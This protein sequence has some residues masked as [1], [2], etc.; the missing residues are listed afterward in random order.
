MR[1]CR[2]VDS[3]CWLKGQHGAMPCRTSWNEA[4]AQ[5]IELEDTTQL[6]RGATPCSKLCLQLVPRTDAM[7]VK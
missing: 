6:R 3:P 7:P 2:A 5:L 1:D 4:E